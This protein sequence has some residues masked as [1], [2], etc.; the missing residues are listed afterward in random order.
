MYG[1]DI[2]DIVRKWRVSGNRAE[3]PEKYGFARTTRSDDG[4]SR[5]ASTV[6]Y[7]NVVRCFTI[8]YNSEKNG[9]FDSTRCTPARR[10]GI[11]VVAHNVRDARRY[12]NI[13]RAGPRTAVIKLLKYTHEL[14]LEVP[15]EKTRA[16]A[17]CRCAARPDAIVFTK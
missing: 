16:H 14:T 12:N 2:F 13:T 17:H 4:S 9:T 6:Q 11:R 1:N 10:L 5:N 3:R 7:C 15:G 8:Y